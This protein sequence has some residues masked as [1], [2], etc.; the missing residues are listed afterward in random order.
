MG[1]IGKLLITTECLKEELAVTLAEQCVKREIK[2]RL[3]QLKINWSYD[4]ELCFSGSISENLKNNKPE[5]KIK[6]Y[7][8]FLNS[9]M[10]RK[11][12]VTCNNILN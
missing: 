4:G 9:R 10:R 2:S 8:L 3:L 1:S 6:L 7:D 12:C 11:C 5:L